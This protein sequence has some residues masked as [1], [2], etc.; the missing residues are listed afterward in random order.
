MAN[1]RRKTPTATAPNRLKQMA[2]HSFDDHNECKR[3]TSSRG[4]VDVSFSV[5][6]MKSFLGRNL[7]GKAADAVIQ[8]WIG[9]G[10]I[11][12]VDI[13][14]VGGSQFKYRFKSATRRYELAADELA[15][16]LLP[17]RFN[18]G[19][20]K[21]A[22]QLFDHIERADWQRLLAMALCA[23]KVDPF[24]VLKKVFTLSVGEQRSVDKV[25]EWIGKL[26]PVRGLVDDKKEIIADW[27]KRSAA[28]Q[29]LT[30]WRNKLFD[31]LC[32]SR[33][34]D[35][36][37]RDDHSGGPKP[38]LPGM[39]AAEARK[40]A[41]DDARQILLEGLRH[42]GQ[43]D[44]NTLANLLNIDPE[45]LIGGVSSRR[46]QLANK[47]IYEDKANTLAV[48]MRAQRPRVG[49]SAEFIALAN[50]ERD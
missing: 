48:K 16:Q 40:K 18:R 19:T 9:A 50:M 5:T 2:F 39:T 8:T 41:E 35:A 31:D 27:A 34:T 28:Q 49:F 22:G 26:H 14:P 44:L 24:M 13:K 47:A 12:P 32:A 45:D 15:V 37:I 17:A 46:G 36:P 43:E 20:P 38:D 7:S 1:K 6:Y 42:F 29:A 21:V 11:V 4:L 33:R 3:R 23:P 30:Q 25:T 10:D